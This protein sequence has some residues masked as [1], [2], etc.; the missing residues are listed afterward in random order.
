MFF[1]DEG[2]E[3]DAEALHLLPPLPLVL[4]PLH[5]R[6]RCAAAAAV[7]APRAAS[8]TCRCSI[9][10]A[11]ALLRALHLHRSLP[12]PLKLSPSRSL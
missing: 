6:R 9:A 5:R 4:L 2:G 7:V 11:P 3:L 12:N 8:L 1:G 10:A